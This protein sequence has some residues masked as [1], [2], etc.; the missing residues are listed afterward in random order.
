VVK[1]IEMKQAMDELECIK[2]EVD[3]DL[4]ELT[5]PSLSSK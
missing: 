4:I 5:F 3:L 2:G 1:D